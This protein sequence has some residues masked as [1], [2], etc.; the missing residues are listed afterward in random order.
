MVT[1]VAESHTDDLNRRRRNYAIAMAVRTLSF[2]AIFFVPGVW[3]LAPLAA[4]AILPFFAVM[5]ANAIDHHAPEP[6]STD[7]DPLL[8]LGTG[9]I[10]EGEVVDNDV[11]GGEV[12][13]AEVDAA[14]DEGEQSGPSSSR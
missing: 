8:S 11:V 2:V 6:I 3:K 14:A 9:E 13:D 12:V 4:A 10:I 1:Q 7:P 5:F